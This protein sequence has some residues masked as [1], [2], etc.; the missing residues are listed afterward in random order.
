MRT[1]HAPGVNKSI[2]LLFF[3]RKRHPL[4]DQRD[5]HVRESPGHVPE[6]ESGGGF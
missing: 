5:M 2:V 3:W 6:K 1:K 4:C